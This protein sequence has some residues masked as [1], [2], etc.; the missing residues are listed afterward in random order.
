MPKFYT[1]AGRGEF[2]RDMLRR[3]CSKF[4]NLQAENLAG[5][6]YVP[7]S[8]KVLLRVEDGFVFRP[9]FERWEYFGWRVIDTSRPGETETPINPHARSGPLEYQQLEVE[10]ARL[11]AALRSIADKLESFTGQQY[12]ELERE[13]RAALQEPEQWRVV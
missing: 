11:R 12:R 8:R 3:D 4:A 1:V 5:D 9:N 6:G 2:P 10:A 7:H 13:A